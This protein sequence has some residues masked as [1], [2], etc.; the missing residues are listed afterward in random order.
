[1]IFLRFINMS[2]F[3]RMGRAPHFD[4]WNGQLHFL[5]VIDRVFFI[6][7]DMISNFRIGVVII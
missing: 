2:A 5:K 7:K 6:Y 1:M 3:I 4:P